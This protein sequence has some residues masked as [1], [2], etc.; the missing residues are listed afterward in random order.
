MEP[1]I[2]NDAVAWTD[3]VQVVFLIIAWSADD[4]VSAYILHI[5]K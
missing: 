5:V 3:V 1:I 2:K 4:H